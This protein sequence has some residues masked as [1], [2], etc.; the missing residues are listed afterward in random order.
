M[1][2]FI[3]LFASLLVLQISNTAIAGKARGKAVFQV[4]DTFGQS[5]THFQRSWLIISNISNTAVTV[6]VRFFQS[7]STLLIDND[8]SPTSGVVRGNN[9]TNYVDNN[10]EFTAEFSIASG[11]TA[12]VGIFPASTAYGWGDIEWSQDDS[13]APTALLGSIWRE[14]YNQALGTQTQSISPI[15]SGEPF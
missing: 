11:Q 12:Q 4:P 15:K 13:E 3:Y 8:N 14:S 10:L 1:K 7:D 5:T 9:V 6:R 2:I